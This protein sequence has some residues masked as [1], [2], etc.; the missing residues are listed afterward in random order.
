ML[1]YQR[2]FQL[3]N[4][5]PDEPTGGGDP[6]VDPPVEEPPSEP[7]EPAAGDDPPV[8][9][10]PPVPSTEE[11]EAKNAELKAAHDRIH[12][13]HQRFMTQTRA[14]VPAETYRAIKDESKVDD[15]SVDQTDET[16][17]VADMTMAQLE[18]S[19]RRIAREDRAAAAKEATDR[20]VRAEQ[21]EVQQDLSQIAADLGLTTQETQQA[22]DHVK[23]YGIDNSVPGGSHALGLAISERMQIIAQQKNAGVRSRATDQSGK[24]RIQ[25]NAATEQPPR[26]AVPP[27]KA[28]T[29][30]Q[31]DLA[32]MNRAVPKPSS[33][34]LDSSQR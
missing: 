4:F 19:Q 34:L 8:D 23:L 15:T 21:H 33:S 13:T 11:L 6:P 7:A 2:L 1:N 27:G 26:G 9:E 25:S 3:K 16:P 17:L 14:R 30:E 32:A 24:D 10:T 29:K 28:K 22:I 31:E 18:A 5:A 12:T 20:Q